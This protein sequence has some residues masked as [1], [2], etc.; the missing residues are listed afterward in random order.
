MSKRVREL[1]SSGS[2]EPCIT[3]GKQKEYHIWNALF[4]APHTGSASEDRSNEPSPSL[5]YQVSVER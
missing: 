1:I 4:V 5:D 2:G 3:L